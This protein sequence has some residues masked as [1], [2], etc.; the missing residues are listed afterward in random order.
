MPSV[1]TYDR[2][3]NVASA[4]GFV[5]GNSIVGVT[6]KTI[7]VIANVNSTL[8][9]LKVKIDNTQQEF[10]VGETITDN[11]FI[12]TNLAGTS[13]GEI[14]TSEVIVSTKTIT[15]I[16]KADPG[17][18]TAASHGFDNGDTIQITG[19]VGMTQVNGNRYKVANKTTDTFELLNTDT[20]DFSTYTSAGTVTQID[21]IPFFV[22]NTISSDSILASTS[23]SAI[24]NSP[25]IA[26]KTHSFKT[27]S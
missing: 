2:I 7:G 1:R 21:K 17:V 22:A 4:S 8:N 15:A 9:Q 3:L 23:I 11:V 13:N 12:M 25:F 26:E 24:A 16:T 14:N 6:S 20:T 27:L 19:V 5:S 18:V 10:S